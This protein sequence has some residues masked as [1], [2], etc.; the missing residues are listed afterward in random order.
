MACSVAYLI[1]SG[2]EAQQRSRNAAR[3]EAAQYAVAKLSSKGLWVYST[4]GQSVKYI[5][6]LPYEMAAPRRRA[7]W[8]IKKPSL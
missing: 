5:G 2:R 7:Q 3:S 1:K 6:I 4:K 8:N